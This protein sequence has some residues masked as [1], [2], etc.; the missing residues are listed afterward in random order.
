MLLNPQK[1]RT[2]M[3]SVFGPAECH[4]V[5]ASIF[6]CCIKCAFQQSS[7]IKRILDVFPIPDDEEKDLYTQMQCM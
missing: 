5:L 2:S 1:F 3:L 4:N 6:D 7:F